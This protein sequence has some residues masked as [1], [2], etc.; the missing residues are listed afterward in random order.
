MQAL[1]RRL[2]SADTC[3][4]ISGHERSRGPSRTA[5]KPASFCP[6]HC[7]SSFCWLSWHA[8]LP[9]FSRDDRFSPVAPVWQSMHSADIGRRNQPVPPDVHRIVLTLCEAVPQPCVNGNQC[10]RSTDREGQSSEA[11]PCRYHPQAQAK[12]LRNWEGTINR[13]SPVLCMSVLCN[14]GIVCSSRVPAF[15]IVRGT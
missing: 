1:P 15:G 11:R 7:G 9:H 3:D 10:H 4:S 13:R 2:P 12:P 6:M 14:G 8:R 5:V